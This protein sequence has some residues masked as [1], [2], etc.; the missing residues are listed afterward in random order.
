MDEPL[1]D[2]CQLE[3]SQKVLI[4]FLVLPYEGR[5][6]IDVRTGGNVCGQVCSLQGAVTFVQT[7]FH[8][9]THCG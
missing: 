7:V 2:A 5:G 9:F 4:V 3:L 6:C 1:Y 8:I